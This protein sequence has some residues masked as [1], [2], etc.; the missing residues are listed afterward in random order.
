M[1]KTS[2][3]VTVDMD[4]LLV[5]KTKVDN[6]SKYLNECLAGLAG[7]TQEDRT[8]EQLEFELASIKSQMQ[9][10]SIKQSMAQQSIKE[11]EEVK[12][13]KIKES[14]ENEQFKRWI[15]PVFR[16]G[17]QNFMTDEKCGSCHLPTRYDSKTT[18][19]SI[20]GD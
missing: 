4:T 13:L 3:C 12:A 9:E 11:I 7:K 10:L 1:K 2:I 16:C 8:K 20:K 15:C 5:A 6:V 14:L 19:I 17:H 18:I